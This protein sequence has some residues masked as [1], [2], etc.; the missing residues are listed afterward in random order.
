MYSSYFAQIPSIR[1][2]PRLVVRTTGEN[3][4]QVPISFVTMTDK[5]RISLGIWT[6]FDEARKQIYAALQSVRCTVCED[7]ERC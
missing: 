1:R 5:N 3:E 4:T 7:P 6:D 2:R